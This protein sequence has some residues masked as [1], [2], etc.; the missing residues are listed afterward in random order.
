M[1]H[2]NIAQILG[3]Y[4]EFVGAIAVV[5]TLAFLA[6]QVRHSRDALTASMAQRRADALNQFSQSIS[7]WQMTVFGDAELSD[8]VLRGRADEVLGPAEA[9]RFLEVAGQFFVRNRSVYA[10][11]I[12]SGNSGQANMTVIGTVFNIANY[13]GMKRVWDSRHRYL[14]NLVVPEFVS[15]VDSKLQASD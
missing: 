15:E 3:S 14:A 10:S 1:D 7:E 12:A 9:E 11:A 2:Q 4:G 8:L 5:A 6:V 13:P